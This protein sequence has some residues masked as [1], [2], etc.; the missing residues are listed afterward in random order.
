MKN[1]LWTKNIISLFQKDEL[2]NF[3]PKNE[4]NT[5]EKINSITRLIFY[6]SIC[7]SI[8]KL[9]IN[10][11]F[12]FIFTILIT[13]LLFN[14]IN[15][16]KYTELFTKYKEDWI[17][18]NTENPFTN[19][20][21]HHYDNPQKESVL[22]DSYLNENQKHKIQSEMNDYFDKNLYKNIDDV[23]NTNNSQRQFY[24]TPITSIPNKQGEFADW[25]Y[26]T[27][28]TCKEFNSECYN[29]LY[30]PLNKKYRNFNTKIYS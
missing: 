12:L 29:N 15:K 19:I 23:F 3:F 7:L 17:F 30:N 14:G 22:S 27:D 18:P 24:T 21:L 5:Y 6:I 11:M 2:L 9:N 16:L 13:L 10:Y 1:N 20:L 8:Y 28:P 4:M 26:K 25:L